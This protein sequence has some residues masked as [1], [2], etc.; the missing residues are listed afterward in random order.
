MGGFGHG[1]GACL[2]EGWGRDGTVS[3]PLP[4]CRLKQQSVYVVVGRASCGL[5]GWG[6]ETTT[7]NPL[8]MGRPFQNP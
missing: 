1:V 4:R 3:F 7:S 6:E 2:L 8:R 5:G